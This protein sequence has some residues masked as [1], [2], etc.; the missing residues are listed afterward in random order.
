MGKAAFRYAMEGK[1]A[2]MPTIVRESSS[3]YR[4]SV[5]EAR[6]SDVANVEKK[7]PRN[8]ITEDG[9]GITPAAREYF[10]PLIIGEDYP[11]FV[12]GLPSYARLKK[13]LVEKK[14]PGWA[15]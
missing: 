6:L 15:N 4:W 8:F 13:V 7:M 14:L 2:V 1:N 11:P 5:G 3:P 12:N 10:A 9:F